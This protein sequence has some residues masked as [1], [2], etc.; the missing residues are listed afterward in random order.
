VAKLRAPKPSTHPVDV[1]LRTE[2]VI[3]AELLRRGY[4]VLVPFGVNQ[5]YDLVID[6][7]GEFCTGTECI[8]AVPIDEAPGAG[9]SLRVDPAANGQMQGIRWAHEYELPG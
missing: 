6:L 2:A 1:G 5:R 4:Q 9:M 8:Y 3:L 7:D